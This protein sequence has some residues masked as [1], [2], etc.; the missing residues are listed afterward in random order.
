MTVGLSMI[1]NDAEAV[2]KLLSKYGD[3]FD[4]WFITYADKDKKQYNRTKSGAFSKDPRL[5]LS[6]YKWD[7]NFGKARQFNQEQIDTDYWMWIDSDDHIEGIENLKDLLAL[8]QAQGLDAMYCL[9]D[10]MQNEQGESVAPHWRERLIRTNSPLKWADSRCHETLTAQSASTARTD[11]MVVVHHKTKKDEEKSMLRNIELLKLDFQETEDPRTA[12]YLGDNLM[13]LKEFDQAL[14]YFTVLLQRGGWDEDKYRAWLRIAEINYQLDKFGDA[15]MA[16]N[17]AEDLLPDFPDSYFLKASIYN[18]MNKPKQC[19]EWVKVGMMKPLPET[20]SVTDPTLYEYRGIFMGALAA[21]ELGKIEEAY[22]LFVIVRKRSPNYEL[23]VEMEPLFTEAMEDNE[24]FKR[25]RPLLYYI[26]DRG[27]DPAKV[28][29]GLPAKILADPRLNAD[30][31]KLI[32]KTSW[33]KGSIVFYCGQSGSTWGADTLDKGMGGSEEAIVYLSR[34]LAKLG[35]QV[36]IFNDR[37]EEHMDAVSWDIPAKVTYKPWTLLNPWDEF[38]T[39]V[40]WRA[41]ENA[42][43]VKAKTVLVDLHD[44]IQAERVYQAAEENSKIKFMV[45]SKWHRSLYPDLPDENFVVVGNGIVKEQFN[46]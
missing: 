13:Y 17:A 28:L 23:A 4:K 3:H 39:F 42:R 27:G 29:G 12:M 24:A 31:A 11:Q 20:L 30:R 41:P 40:A 8:M 1:S 19:Y 22:K 32:P 26:K 46:A 5:S 16:C 33:P 9:Y 25:L 43:G 21:L 44:T 2:Y 10:Y 36:T 38:D 7:D 37:E 14:A 34:E 6:Y 15:L 45:K 35:H 18:A